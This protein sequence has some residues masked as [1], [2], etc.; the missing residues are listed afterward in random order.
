MALRSPLLAIWL[1]EQVQAFRRAVLLLL[2][3]SAA[4]AV[5]GAK[6]RRRVAKRGSGGPP[7]LGARKRRAVRFD[8][9]DNRGDDSAAHAAAQ[10]H[11]L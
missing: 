6:E 5:A 11:V 3:F 10:S 4:A 2:T 7:P 9:A 1:C 8:R